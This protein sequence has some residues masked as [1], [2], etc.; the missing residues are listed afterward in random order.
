MSPPISPSSSSSGETVNGDTKPPESDNKAKS[1]L[2][3]LI[4]AMSG[5]I[6]KPETP[7]SPADQILNKWQLAFNVKPPTPTKSPNK[8]TVKE[9]EEEKTDEKTEVTGYLESS[10][11]V[12]G[13]RV[14][15]LRTNILYS[16][17]VA[18]VAPNKVLSVRFKTSSFSDLQQYSEQDLMKNAV[19]ERE[20]VNGVSVSNNSRV[21]IAVKNNTDSFLAGSVVD[22]RNGVYVVQLDKGGFE[23]AD[24]E[25][26]RLLPQDYPKHKVS[27]EASEE[28]TESKHKHK[29]NILLGYDFVD[30]NDTDIVAWDKAI[31][32]RRKVDKTKSASPPLAEADIKQEADAA[33]VKDDN[34]D[35]DDG[36]ENISAEVN[37]SVQS[38]LDQVS[39]EDRMRI[40]LLSNMLKKHSP[41]KEVTTKTP[42]NKS[43]KQTAEVVKKEKKRKT[44]KDSVTNK[45]LSLEEEEDDDLSSELMEICKESNID[46]SKQESVQ[47]ENKIEEISNNTEAQTE[48]AQDSTV[49]TSDQLTIDEKEETTEDKSDNEPSGKKILS[50]CYSDPVM[51]GGWYVMV[52]RRLDGKTC[53][54]YYFTPCNTKLRSVMEIKKFLSGKLKSKPLKKVRKNIESLPKRSDLSKAKR[55]MT[56]D[57]PED[58]FEKTEE[59]EKDEDTSKEDKDHVFKVPSLESFRSQK[60]KSSKTSSPL[61]DETADDEATSEDLEPDAEDE[62]K[63]GEKRKRRVLRSS[64]SKE[65]SSDEEEDVKKTDVK[66]RKTRSQSSSNS[67]SES[68]PEDDKKESK[69]QSETSESET[70]SADETNT[71]KKKRKVVKKTRDTSSKEENGS[72]KENEHQTQ[73]EEKSEPEPINGKYPKTKKVTAKKTSNETK[74]RTLRSNTAE[75]STSSKEDPKN[76]VKEED[77]KEETQEKTVTRNKRKASDEA[78]DVRK[79]KKPSLSADVKS[80]DDDQSSMNN[81]RSPSPA[82]KKLLG[83]AS[84]RKTTGKKL[85]GPKSKRKPTVD[86]EEEEEDLEKYNEKLSA[87]TVEYFKKKKHPQTKIKMMSLFQK[88]LCR[89]ECGHCHEAGHFTLHLVDFDMLDK[90]ASMQCTACHWTTVRKMNIT[91][92]IVE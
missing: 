31:K 51:P 36:E 21:A 18:N 77:I 2:S 37:Q 71:K 15:V 53:D 60:N 32:R 33:D 13:T 1:R 80:E 74:K 54:T 91:T 25:H 34:V 30:E 46:I 41:K 81:N 92:R 47:L 75:D 83:P 59:K 24:A 67:E 70:E 39:L 26:I 76:E 78:E 57:L 19:L 29:H 20:I 7:A 48:E 10:H 14:L 86:D 73:A 66:K 8:T 28:K 6:K 56:K 11:L 3:N 23:E 16:A 64:A 5:K 49:D 68:E 63:E 55:A 69:S 79:T 40:S 90:T 38:M 87:A 42:G 27:S 85:L 89:A 9:E 65:E 84:Q 12:A 35:A 61:V 4:Q 82:K 72:D 62:P 88:S 50:F 43:P 22:Y 44:S 52:K 58:L 17:T 45:R